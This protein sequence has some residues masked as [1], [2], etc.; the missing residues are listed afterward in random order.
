MTI[1]LQTSLVIFHIIG[2]VLGTGAATAADLLILRRTIFEPIEDSVVDTVEF[3]SKL[4]T[5]GLIFLWISGIGLA[6]VIWSKNPA[7]VTNEKFWAKVV[8]VTVLTVNA[9]AIHAIILPKLRHLTGKR[10]FDRLSF[11]E[12]AT[13]I[14]SAS[15][16]GVSW[17]LPLVLGPAREWSY[18]VPLGVVLLLY[19]FL[20]CSLSFAMA[21]LVL[22]STRERQGEEAVVAQRDWPQAHHSWHPQSERGAA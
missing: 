4:V 1:S 5:I 10:L 20:L 8:I 13:F 9:F 11:R 19:V 3:L 7:F 12:Q 2:I 17:Y 14:L 6:L 16:S 22:W 18:V 21:C 15:V